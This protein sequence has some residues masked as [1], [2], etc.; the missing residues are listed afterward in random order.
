MED[1]AGEVSGATTDLVIRVLDKYGDPSQNPHAGSDTTPL[2]DSPSVSEQRIDDLTEKQRETLRQIYKHPTAS[3]RDIASMLDVS[4]TAVYNRLQAIEGFEW[5]DRWK[6][7]NTLYDGD[8]LHVE[9]GSDP[10]CSG[11]SQ[12][13]YTDHKSTRGPTS[14]EE[15]SRLVCKVLRACIK[16]DEITERELGLITRELSP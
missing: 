10:N 14:I 15:R 8:D 1:I 11:H 3:Q 6:F 9:G 2:G 13:S 12:L 4:Q 16:A 5:A 7:V